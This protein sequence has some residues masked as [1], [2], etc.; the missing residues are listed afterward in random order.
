MFRVIA[1]HYLRES[2]KN[3]VIGARESR[4]E[5]KKPEK[6]GQNGRRDEI[7]MEIA[8]EIEISNFTPLRLALLPVA[9]NPS[10]DSGPEEIW[11]DERKKRAKG[12]NVST[13]PNFLLCGWKREIKG[14]IDVAPISGVV[15]FLFFPFHF[16]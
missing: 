4:E 14:Q 5:G 1:F 15:T 16:Q 11:K 9:S 12:G 10:Q 3:R 6:R 8:V 13:D 7:E 2:K